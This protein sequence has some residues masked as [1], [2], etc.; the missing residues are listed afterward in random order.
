VS[1]LIVTAH[2]DDE[3]LFCGA[4]IAHA[5]RSGRDVVTVTLTHGEAGRTLGICEPAKLADVRAAELQAAAQELGIH[6]VEIF[7]LPDGEIANHTRDAE[8]LIR[9]ALNRWRPS[10]VVTYPPNGINGHPDHVAVH[11]ATLA[12]LN[13][14]DD[15][16]RVLLI[17]DPTEFTEPARQGF[18]QPSE[19]NRLRLP[20]TETVRA[21]DAIAMKLRAL[22]CYETQSRSITKRLRLYTEQILVERFHE[23][24]R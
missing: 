14:I 16:P 18:L 6:A 4:L 22:G 17:T 2:P 24:Q 5:T 8:R 12:A 13:E 15:N 10:V 19:V 21:D 20:A 3:A 11:H 7:R 1:L 9:A 23:L